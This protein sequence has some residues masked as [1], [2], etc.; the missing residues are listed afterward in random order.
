MSTFSGNIGREEEDGAG[1]EGLE[2]TKAEREETKRWERVG[3]PCGIC[4][5]PQIRRRE[6]TRTHTECPYGKAE[7]T[8]PEAPMKLARMLK[9]YAAITDGV[10]QKQI[11][12][13]AGVS[14]STLSRFLS[15]EQMPDGRAI[16]A[17][18]SWS[19]K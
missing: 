10:T 19:L 6:C 1:W 13:E 18:I 11:A 15:G 12:Q 2:P 7:P 8:V 4:N 16:A 3:G 14:E 9:L 5:L 17:L